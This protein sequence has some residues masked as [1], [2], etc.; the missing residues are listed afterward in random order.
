M[1]YVPQPAHKAGVMAN[2]AMALNVQKCRD[3]ERFNRV[4][5]VSRLRS[6]IIHNVIGRIYI[7]AVAPKTSDTMTTK[8]SWCLTATNPATFCTRD[9]P[10]SSPRKYR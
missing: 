10:I 3:L 1:S 9:H 4:R 5:F 6:P 7:D 8:C 2:P